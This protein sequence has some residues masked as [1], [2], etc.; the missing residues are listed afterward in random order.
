MKLQKELGVYLLL[1]IIA[2]GI[3]GYIRNER[4]EEINKT[5]NEIAS[6]KVELKKINKV[7]EKVDEAKAKKKRIK[8]IIK[9]ID[10]L[11]AKQRNPARII[12]DINLRLPSE[13]WLTSFNETDEMITLEGYSFSDPGLAV[14]MKNLEKLTNY[15]SRIDFVESRQVKIS[16]EKVRKFKIQCIRK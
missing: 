5:N 13:A 8:Q 1:I 9:R 3:I 11:K 2:L 4:K 7:V 15:F 6:W 14:F 10:I 16:G 12:D